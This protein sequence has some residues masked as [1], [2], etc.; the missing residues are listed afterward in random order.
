MY[1]GRVPFTISNNLTGLIKAGTPLFQIIPFKRDSWQSKENNKIIKT[2]T[3]AQKK[4]GSL[5]FG[6]YRNNAWTKK[7]FS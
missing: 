4:F 5:F 1:P 6:G 2:A 3:L 7:D